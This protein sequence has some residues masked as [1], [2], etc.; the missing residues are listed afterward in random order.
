MKPRLA[1]PRKSLSPPTHRSPAESPLPAGRWPSFPKKDRAGSR[2]QPGV[3]SHR[4]EPYLDIPMLAGGGAGAGFE[5][6]A[7]KLSVAAA[8]AATAAIL[9]NFIE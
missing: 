7:P 6:Q 2:N 8:N 4:K 5:A 1:E 3:N 9:M